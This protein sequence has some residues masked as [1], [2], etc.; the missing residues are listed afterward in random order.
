VKDDIMRRRE[1]I[2]LLGGAAAAWP[3]AARA[4][5]PALPVVG[6]F[7]TGFADASADRVRAFRRGLSESGYVEGQNV[8][9]EYHWLEGQ[10]DRLP[11]LMANLVRRRVAVIATPA[12]NTTA[13]AAKAATATIPIVFGVAADPVKL[14]LVASLARPGGNATGFNFFNG[15]VNAKR[16][17]LLHE[18]VPKAAR[19]A[20]F[21]NP[22]NATIMETTL[23][24]VQAAARTVALQI[25]KLNATTIGEIDAAFATLA[26]ERPDALFVAPDGF[27][28]TRRVQFATLTTRERIPAAYGQREFVEVGGLMSYGTNIADSFRQVGIYT[29]SILKGAKPSDLPVVQSTRFEFV[30]NLGTAKALGIEVPPTLLAITDAVIE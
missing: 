22:A 4:Q 17:G 23:Q 7:D 27:F 6:F 12:G 11:T 30:I 20:V 5:Q 16:L 10:Y 26:R 2:T 14:G 1:V 15:E 13:L 18:L 29:G 28:V 24:D 21:V 8:T 9:V 3:L 19:V 25:Q